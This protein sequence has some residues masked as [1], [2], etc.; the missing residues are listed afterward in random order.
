[1][2]GELKSYQSLTANRLPKFDVLSAKD[3][4]PAQKGADKDTLDHIN[5][6]GILDSGAVFSFVSRPLTEFHPEKEFSWY[7]HGT[8]GEIEVIGQRIF[9]VGGAVTIKVKGEDGTIEDIALDAP[10]PPSVNIAKVYEAW[11]TGDPKAADFREALRRHKFLD[12]IGAY[13]S[14]AGYTFARENV[15]LE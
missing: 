8:K 4:K 12:T 15:D 2:V 10:H 7:I 3:G 1:M 5:I 9:S 11:R 6:Q 14:G 13:N